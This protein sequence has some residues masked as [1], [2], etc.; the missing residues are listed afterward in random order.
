[1]NIDIDL[2]SSPLFILKKM[3]RNSLRLNSGFLGG[4]VLDAGCADKPYQR[5]ISSTRYIGIEQAAHSRADIRAAAASLPF[6]DVSFDT[7]ICTELLE[8]I[9]KPAACLAEIRRV[10]KNGGR[11]YI[12]V[13][14]SWYLHYEPQDYWRF[15]RYGLEYLLKEEGFKVFDI[16]RVG[17]FFSISAVGFTDILWTFLQKAFSFL[18][19]S[20]AEKT[21]SWF[22]LPFSLIFY[23]L[24]LMLDKLEKRYALGWT[25]LAVK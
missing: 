1:M 10:L 20:I 14:Q 13:P 21:A 7:V 18:G 16:K 5:F 19:A 25:V 15:T 23:P 9:L 8:H 11:L 2:F 6:K 4:C 22:C 3:Q 12:S 17:G 24:A